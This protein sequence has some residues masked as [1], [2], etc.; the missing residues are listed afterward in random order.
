MSQQTFG[1][2]PNQS[3]TI[4]LRCTIIFSEILLL[5]SVST[6]TTACHIVSPFTPMQSA[7][8]SEHTCA[9]AYTR[10]SSCIMSKSYSPDPSIPNLRFKNL[11]PNL[12]WC[13]DSAHYRD[14]FELWSQICTQSWIQVSDLKI[15]VWAS[16]L[17][18]TCLQR[19][20]DEW[21]HCQE[22]KSGPLRRSGIIIQMSIELLSSML[23]K[24]LLRSW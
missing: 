24:C 13:L 10:Y 2:P 19:P 9:N 4:I 16:S 15:L 8:K 18:N 21:Y 3:Q 1:K 22:K 12:N 20:S 5:H 17:G 7:T 14:R 11:S 6:V 23:Q